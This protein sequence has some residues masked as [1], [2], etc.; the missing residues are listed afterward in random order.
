MPKVGNEELKNIKCKHRTADE[1]K[2]LNNRLSVIAGQI[3]GIAKMVEEDRCCEEILGQLSSTEN[4][5]KS[6]G[7]EM[8]KSHLSSTMFKN[9][10][11]VDLEQMDE[12]FYL[13][14]KVN[15]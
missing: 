8:L 5:L 2:K 10:K 1:K 14:K 9:S 12:I 4:S 15:M 11:D 3:K 7:V 6:V 13:M